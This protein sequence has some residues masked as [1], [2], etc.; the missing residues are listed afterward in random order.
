M[1]THDVSQMDGAAPN[2]TTLA[3][4]DEARQLAARFATT[5]SASGDAALLPNNVLPVE[6]IRYLYAAV[7]MNAID[8]DV[9]V[10]FA[11]A[12]ERAVI[13]RLLE[14]GGAHQVPVTTYL[15]PDGETRWPAYSHEQRQ[16]YA[17]AAVLKAGGSRADY[18]WID[19]VIKELK[20][21]PE[22]KLPDDSDELM[23]TEN[24]LLAILLRHA[25]A[26][27]RNK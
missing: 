2:A 12:I 1:S 20:A 13:E 27:N 9:V 23:A 16:E 19:A 6:Q 17:A 24:E 11:Q 10:P 25:P 15:A 3:A 26:P 4:M 5:A 8:N 7:C 22:G 14:A 18:S 21:L